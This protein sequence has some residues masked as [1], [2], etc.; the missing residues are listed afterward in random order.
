MAQTGWAYFGYRSGNPRS[1]EW[2]WEHINNGGSVAVD[3]ETVSLEDKTLIGYS[4]AP[5]PFEAWWFFPDNPF[6]TEIKQLLTGPNLKIFHNG[7]FDRPVLEDY[8]DIIVAPHS[9]TLFMAQL[10]GKTNLTLHDL[11]LFEYGQRNTTIKELLADHDTKS[12]LDIPI[13][14][15]VKKCCIDSET[16]M[17][18]YGIMEP[19]VP[20]RAMDL[21]LRV[22]PAVEAMNKQGMHVDG[23]RLNEHIV[24]TSNK[25]KALRMKCDGIGFNPGS[26]QQVASVLKR[27]GHS[28]RYN[29]ETGNPKLAKKILQTYHAYDPLVKDILEY[30]KLRSALSTRLIGLQNSLVKNKTYIKFFQGGAA[31]GRISTS[32]NSQNIEFGY[33]DIY[34]SGPGNILEVW[35]FSQVELRI[36]AWMSQDPIMLEAFTT[37]SS[38]HKAT[39]RLMY[40]VNYTKDQYRLAKNIN[41]TIVYGGD[42]WTLYERYGTP[43]ETGRYYMAVW[44]DI[45]KVA[46]SY[47]T[48]RRGV[49]KEKGYAETLYGRQRHFPFQN[50]YFEQWE[51]DKFYREAINHEIQGTAGEANKELLIYCH[52]LKLDM[53]NTVHDEVMID[54][55]MFDYIDLPDFDSFLPLHT[56]IEGGRGWTWLDAKLDA[57]R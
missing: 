40:G 12:M 49:I 43:L 30:R 41:F 19:D 52:N 38:I 5:N 51:L 1:Y 34:I 26:P 22:Q 18:I 2:L 15:V 48:Y 53:V 54:T 17:G 37:G 31:S 45:Y 10:L 6:I 28:I 16:T 39:A 42:E 21:E 3:I 13:E 29:K 35:D 20:K 25:V 27:R 32:P 4:I 46:F 50:D 33:R 57:D 23:D 55:N 47:L 7:T 11:G 14:K 44:R 36:L 56:P 24:I 8:Y 9:D